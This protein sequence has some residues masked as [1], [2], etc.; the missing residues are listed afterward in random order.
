M[1]ALKELIAPSSE[2]GRTATGK[3][4]PLRWGG[5][6]MAVDP[7]RVDQPSIV[8]VVPVVVVVV[9]V[10]VRMALVPTFLAVVAAIIV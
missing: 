7:R 5:S 4:E 6:G 3:P 2:D 9:V 8:V 10:M 1:E